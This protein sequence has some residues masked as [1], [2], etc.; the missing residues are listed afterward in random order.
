MPPPPPHRR[1]QHRHHRHRHHQPCFH[2]LTLSS[3]CI[4][5]PYHQRHP[6]LPHC[7]HRHHRRP[8]HPPDA[9]G[10]ARRGH[11]DVRRL[12]GLQREDQPVRAAP[13]RAGDAPRARPHLAL[14]RQPGLI[15]LCI[16]R[17]PALSL[18]LPSDWPA[19]AV[20][21]LGACPDM[22]FSKATT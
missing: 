14:P 20:E 1:H 21:L 7:H 5:R 22:G 13:G 15:S 17:R 2:H 3:V 10:G 19:M 9:P 11:V 18:Q 16:D 8:H 12:D 4:A 6:H